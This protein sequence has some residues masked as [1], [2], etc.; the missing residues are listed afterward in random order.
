[1]EKQF[2]Y[3]IEVG[4]HAE[5]KELTVEELEEDIYD[6]VSQIG[7]VNDVIVRMD[8]DADQPLMELIRMAKNQLEHIVDIIKDAAEDQNALD[9]YETGLKRI[10]DG[11]TWIAS[12]A[13][14]VEVLHKRASEFKD[15]LLGHV[16]PV[17]AGNL[18]QMPDE[19]LHA[20][21]HRIL[22]EEGADDCTIHQ[23]M[24]REELIEYI[25]D[26]MDSQPELN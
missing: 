22:H 1:M 26:R 17:N 4:V 12:A 7:G 9:I 16:H 5:D 2:R 8:I 24:G 10:D 6:A 14:T 11:I 23:T 3:N 25:K 19:V 13:H 20:I 15:S 21:A 18:E